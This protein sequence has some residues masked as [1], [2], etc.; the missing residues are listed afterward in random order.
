MNR[1]T[2]RPGRYKLV[3]LT[4]CSLFLSLSGCGCSGSHEYAYA[5]HVDCEESL[6]AAQYLHLCKTVGMAPGGAPV[7]DLL[8][9]RSR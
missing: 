9:T 5:L 1:K 6:C 4:L 8:E 7:R 3:A 2:Y